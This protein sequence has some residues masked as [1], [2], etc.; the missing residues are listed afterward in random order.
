MDPHS[1]S[2]PL[3]IGMM[4]FPD[5]TQLDLTGPYEVFTRI[6]AVSVHL[7]AETLQPVRSERGL[8]ITP[9]G[10]WVTSPQLDVIF[11]PGGI[12]VN[13]ML[14]HA[15]LLNF[16]AEQSQ[17]A[18]YVTAVCTGT[19]V[20]GAAGLLRGYRAATHWLSMDLLPL[21]GAEP[22]HERVVIDRNRITGGGITAGIDFGLRVAALLRDEHTAQEIQ[23]MLEYNPQPPFQSGSPDTADPALV[24]QVRAARQQVQAAR[25]VIAERVERRLNTPQE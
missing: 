22:V 7:L 8:T 14:E 23:L 17:S 12:G 10:T 20:L 13:A 24:Q 6:P 11:V 2:R 4:L 1:T 3:S 16:L 5:L 9:D 18:A 21:F 25:R 15:P 19:L